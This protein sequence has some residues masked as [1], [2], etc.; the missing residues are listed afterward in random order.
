MLVL[1][2]SVS[3]RSV[4]KI[5]SLFQ[6]NSWIPHFTSVI[7]W[8]LRLGLGLLKQV[9]PIK[10]PWIAILDHSIDI[11]T[12]K[13]F[14][15]LRVE[16]DALSKRGSAITLQDCE[17][18][19][20]TVHETVNGEQVYADLVEIFKKSGK[21]T[22]IIKDG[23]SSLQ[24]GCKL[25]SNT[26]EGKA[27]IIYDIGHSMAAALKEEYERTEDYINFTALVSKAAHRL[28][29]TQLAFLMPP[30]LRSKGRFQSLSKLGAWAEKIFNVLNEKT[31][32]ADILAKLNKALPDFLSFATFINGFAKTSL[33]ISRVLEILKNKGLN[34]DTHQQCLALANELPEQ[35]IVKSRLI[36]W[37]TTHS[38]VQQ[39]IAPEGLSLPVSSDIVESLFG[40]YKYAAARNPQADT[41]RMVLLIPAL[42]GKHDELSIANAFRHAPHK[43]I[44][45]WEKE[46]IAYTVRKKRLEFL[47]ENS[48]QKQREPKAA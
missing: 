41:N 47:N 6:P 17:C 42:C 36:D 1:Q 23:D 26:Q 8:T 22:A 14:I 11:G 40:R 9:K 20:V 34:Q 3:Y 19:G 12:K 27:E 31:Q 32:Q 28:R 15:V 29:Q 46:N 33:I 21:P 38:A 5:L 35:S 39:K 44:D 30:K 18:I 2:A 4:P 16:L 7:N 45:E 37:L 43:A 13:A 24:K 25:W 48:S 10:K